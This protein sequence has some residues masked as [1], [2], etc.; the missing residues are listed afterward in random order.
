MER[1]ARV[2]S[3][4]MTWMGED[5][6][7]FWDRA[8]GS[9]VWDVDGNRLLDLTAAFGVAGPGHNHP[10][11]VAAALE[12][13]GKL[14]HGMGDVH[15][16]EA[17]VLF[18]ERLQKILPERLGGAILGLNGSDAVEAAL[19]AA[20]FHTGRPGVL[21]FEG[22]YHGLLGMSL[23]T[24]GAARFREPFAPLLAD[25]TQWLPFPSGDAEE[26]ERVLERVQRL[27]ASPEA[28]G[29]VL[30]EP[31]QG[32]GGVVVPPPGFLGGLRELC[33]GSRTVLIL[34]EIFTGMGRTGRRFALESEG[35]LPDLLVLGKA[36]T[37]GMPLSVAVGT[38]EVMGSWPRT[39]GEALHTATYLG[40]PVACAVGTAAIDILVDEGLAERSQKMGALA[41]EWLKERLGDLVQVGT[42]RG[43]GLMVGIPLLDAEGRPSSKLASAV[44]HS[45]L[46]QG[47]LVLGSGPGGHVLSLTP[48]LSIPEALLEWGIE[49]LAHCIRENV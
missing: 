22:G 46:A 11:L 33:D 13:T 24:N 47:I 44:T 31:I 49:R 25:S 6:P 2:E 38:P 10:R 5:F 35:I 7:V 28:P 32:R 43:R 20:H 16:P 3:S 14:M 34:D 36:L 30:V 41:Q 40:H 12:Q 27:L 1:L 8:L 37:G 23:A 21:A 45:A 18:L 17:K 19:K 4:G 26:G 42:I 15:P 9:N 29:A 39:T 48:P